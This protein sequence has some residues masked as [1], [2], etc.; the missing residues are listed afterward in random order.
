MVAERRREVRDDT[1][2]DAECRIGGIAHRASLTN[3][4]KYGC[5]AVLDGIVALPGDRVVVRLTDLLI[6]PATVKWVSG[7]QTGLVFANPLIGGMLSQ[8]VVRNGSGRGRLH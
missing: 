3:V 7:T 5:C 2:I 6:V 8:F 1:W 4:T